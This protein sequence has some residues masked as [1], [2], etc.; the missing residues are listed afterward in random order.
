MKSALKALS[1]EAIK[2][3]HANSPLQVSEQHES[4]WA[5]RI[6]YSVSSKAN[7]LGWVFGDD[8][9]GPFV[10]DGNLN[11]PKYLELLQ[12]AAVPRIK[13]IIE[14]RGDDMDDVIFQQD[15]APVHIQLTHPHEWTHGWGKFIVI[16][17][18]Y[19]K[20]K[21]LN[22]LNWIEYPTTRAKLVG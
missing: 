21:N 20:L 15:G 18:V 10:I 5:P 11:G 16:T 14:T 13:E 22:K 12:D 4:A 3:L 8:I 19:C 1:D 6:P 2:M 9:V 17:V 7:S